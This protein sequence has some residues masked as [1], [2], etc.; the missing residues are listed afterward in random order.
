MTMTGC[1]LHLAIQAVHDAEE[2]V[3]KAKMD[4]IHAESKHIDFLAKEPL[5]GD[6]TWED[7]QETIRLANRAESRWKNNLS[8]D[9]HGKLY[10]DYRVLEERADL[11]AKQRRLTR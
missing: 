11:I 8:K 7:E 4:V 10:L 6:E 3:H 1:M 2:A 9:S 5:K